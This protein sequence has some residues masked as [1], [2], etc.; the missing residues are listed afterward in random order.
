MYVQPS[1]PGDGFIGPLTKQETFERLVAQ[2]QACY[3]EETFW[4]VYRAE[5]EAEGNVFGRWFNTWPRPIYDRDS[6]PDSLDLERIEAK[7]EALQKRDRRPGPSLDHMRVYGCQLRNDNHYWTECVIAARR[8]ATHMRDQTSYVSAAVFAL[9]R[10]GGDAAQLARA[11]NQLAPGVHSLGQTV[12]RVEQAT[13]EEEQVA[14]DL[15]LAK[16]V[17]AKAWREIGRARPNPLLDPAVS[18]FQPIG[19][20]AG[21]THS[22][23]VGVQRQENAAEERRLHQMSPYIPEALL[24]H[25]R[26]CQMLPMMSR[27][28]APV[29]TMASSMQAPWNYGTS[30]R[31]TEAATAAAQASDSM[32]RL[33]IQELASRAASRHAASSSPAVL[34]QAPMP[35]VSQA[36]SHQLTP[37]R[38]VP[39]VP[40]LSTQPVLLFG[41]HATLNQPTPRH[42]VASIPPVPSQA[43]APFETQAALIPSKH[44]KSSPTAPIPA[45]SQTAVDSVPPA[46]SI[47]PDLR[48]APSSMS[49]GRAMARASPAPQE[50][51]TRPRTQSSPL[52]QQ[53]A[54]TSI[55]KPSSMSYVSSDCYMHPDILP[56]ESMLEAQVESITRD[57]EEHAQ[58]LEHLE[59]R[60][61]QRQSSARKK[62]SHPPSSEATQRIK[63]SWGRM[64]SPFEDVRAFRKMEQQ[65]NPLAWSSLDEANIWAPLGEPSVPSSRELSGSTLLDSRKSSPEDASCD[66]QSDSKS[67]YRIT[68]SREFMLQQGEGATSRNNRLVRDAERRAMSYIPG[69]FYRQRG[70]QP[71]IISLWK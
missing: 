42:M 11:A 7:K 27:A 58:P 53:G 33:G 55:A 62:P 48:L 24:I 17:I 1:I 71:D 6:K 45:T 52:F 59:H 50:P 38:I 5:E 67:S 14:S 64:S 25:P 2:E 18:S 37:R 47:N 69:E 36:Q 68:G 29:P 8:E 30:R 54:I 56:S 26:P 66:V 23:V 13:L 39:S 16:E 49:M 32:R 40:T 60:C 21:A 28:T 61:T 43:T 22:Q 35:P 44:Q 20:V 9:E 65:D 3:D 4:R 41:S 34:E 19:S 31:R 51:Y 63:T 15:N 10:H 70:L 57:Q 12:M 46:L